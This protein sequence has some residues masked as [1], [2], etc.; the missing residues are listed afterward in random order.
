M[1]N[2]LNATTLRYHFLALL[3][4][5]P[6]QFFFSFLFRKEKEWIKLLA[7]T[8]SINF[9][10]ILLYVREKL[11][12]NRDSIVSSLGEMGQWVIRR[13]QKYL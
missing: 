4:L 9:Y 5:L 10:R 13:K 3:V 12:E 2:I 1:C 6:T 8:T 11:T 7:C